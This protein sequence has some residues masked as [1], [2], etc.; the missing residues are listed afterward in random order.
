MTFLL[1][2]LA[3]LALLLF[4]AGCVARLQEEPEAQALVWPPAPDQPRV[5]F[6]RAFSGPADLGIGRGLFGRLEDLILG[7]EQQHQLVRPMAVVA[8]RGAIY[9]ADPGAQG[10]HRFDLDRGDYAL[11]Q[12]AD[13]KPLPSPV[14]LALG[15]AGEVYV[16]DSKLAQVLVIQPGGK[17]AVPVPLGAELGQPTGI[18]FDGQNRRLFVVDTAAHQIVAF[19]LDG[20]PLGTM[21]KRGDGP[22]EFNYPTLLWRSPLGRLYVTDSLNFRVQILEADGDFVGMFGKMGDGM[23]DA[24]RP[25]GVATDSYGHVYVVDSLLHSL[26]IF[27]QSGRFLLPVGQQGQEHGEFW[28]PTGIFVADDNRIYVADSYNR[29]IQVLRYVGGAA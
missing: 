25:K 15:G 22:G 27:D 10:V 6:V 28:L 29:R 13:K 4:L 14:G 20:R 24:P 26:Q 23:G 5:A 12:G 21:G 8:W 17:A 3:G 7:E 2:C 19:R 16:T 18:A 9:V 11:I 1:R